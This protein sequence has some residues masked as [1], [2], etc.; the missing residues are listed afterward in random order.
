MGPERR[1][2]DR[3]GEFQGRTIIL[4]KT[5]VNRTAELGTDEARL[6]RIDPTLDASSPRQRR[7]RVLLEEP[8]PAVAWAAWR[9]LGRWGYDVSWC[10]GPVPGQGDAPERPC[11]LVTAGRCPLLEHADVVVSSLQWDKEACRQVLEALGCQPPGTPV[12]VEVLS[13]SSSRVAPLLEGK[14]VLNTPVVSTTLLAAVDES[15][16]RRAS[17]A[18]TGPCSTCLSPSSVTEGSKSTPCPYSERDHASQA[19]RAP[20]PPR[21]TSCAESLG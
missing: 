10:P 21:A 5:K 16:G 15:V 9:S 1:C 13:P 14:R 12:I 7:H 17:S 18:P 19:A 8:D 4:F 6:W 2:A 20:W 11:A 3:T